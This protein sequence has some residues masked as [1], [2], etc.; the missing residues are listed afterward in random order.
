[1]PTLK[2]RLE[3]ALGRRALH[4]LVSALVAQ[5]AR[6]PQYVFGA[7]TYGRRRHTEIKSEH[8]TVCGLRQALE[9]G[10]KAK[11]RSQGG[12]C[13]LTTGVLIRVRRGC[14]PLPLGRLVHPHLSP[15]ARN[16]FR[17]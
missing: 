2:L 4:R 16:A 15:V 10:K 12:V 13:L 9:S 17:D 5:A 6:E 8:T 3:R 14:N 11:N 1:M 7:A